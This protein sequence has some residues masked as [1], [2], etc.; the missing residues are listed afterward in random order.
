[1]LYTFTFFYLLRWHL[2]FYIWTYHTIFNTFPLLC[3]YTI[4]LFFFNFRERKGGRRR[5]KKNQCERETSNGCK[6]PDQG[7]N[8]EPTTQLGSLTRNR[9][10]DLFVNGMTGNWLSHTVQGY[11]IILNS[12]KNSLLKATVARDN[13]TILHLLLYCHHTMHSTKSFTSS[14]CIKGGKIHNLLDISK[15]T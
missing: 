1:M 15:L 9:T 5:Q 13:N 11:T 3:I 2:H 12:H 7:G 10:G 4:N 14:F 8:M 6:S